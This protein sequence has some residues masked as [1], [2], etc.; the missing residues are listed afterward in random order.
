MTAEP[1]LREKICEIGRRIYNRG[2]VA[3]ND[4]NISVRFT[5]HEILCTPTGV[6][7]GF[8][9]PKSICKVNEF[10]ELIEANGS[11]RPS[12]EMKMHLRIYEKRPD[13]R[14]V[15]HAHPTYGTIFAIAGTALDKPIMSE[16]VVS[17]GSVPVVEYGAPSTMEL[18]D[19]I[20]KYLPY[21][22]ALLLEHHG[23]LTYADS[24]E[25]A[26]MRME[27]LEFYAELLYRTKLIDGQREF[28]EKEI[29]RL[30]NIR[31]TYGMT[32][33][34]PAEVC[35]F[36]DEEGCSTCPHHADE[37][38]VRNLPGYQYPFVG[39]KKLCK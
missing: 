6:S 36:S 39:R 11:F 10:G 1:F 25:N 22:D 23:A 17:L 16:A 34:H 24:L 20:E 18:P 38:A 21:Y 14:A 26:Y 7:K 37:D 33:K 15:V 28:D 32:G 2:M 12:S 29:E 31:S 9:T 5:E 8:M 27:S 13:I 30:Y 19:N 4:G 3:A 35:F